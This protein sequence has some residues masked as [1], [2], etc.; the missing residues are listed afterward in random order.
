MANTIDNDKKNCTKVCLRKGL[1]LYST[2]KYRE[3]IHVI[4]LTTNET[5]VAHSLVTPSRPV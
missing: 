5:R 4:V 1:Y 3:R 2:Y